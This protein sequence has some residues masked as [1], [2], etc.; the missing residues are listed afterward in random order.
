[1]S[2]ARPRPDQLAVD[3]LDDPFWEACARHEFLVQRCGICGASFWPATAC[4]THGLAAMSW[5]PASGRGVVHTYTVYHQV[6][7]QAL[8]D[9]VPYVVGVVKLEEGP[10]FHTNIVGCSPDEVR[11]DMPVEVTFEDLDGGGAIPLFRPRQ[12]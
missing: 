9:Q 12:S 5:T 7:S 4:T 6:Y 11:I 3:D 8:A 10:F 1:M 2:S